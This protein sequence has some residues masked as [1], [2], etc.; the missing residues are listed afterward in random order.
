VATAFIILHINETNRFWCLARL[1]I[2]VCA[3]QALANNK[4]IALHYLSNALVVKHSAIDFI[5]NLYNIG[6]YFCQNGGCIL[7]T[8]VF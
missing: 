2:I 4:N 5:F 8:A 3:R 6:T 1:N 7:E